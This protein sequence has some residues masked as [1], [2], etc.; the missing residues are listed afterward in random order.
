MRA[1]FD[2]TDIGIALNVAAQIVA[3]DG[4][5]FL[6]IFLRLETEFQAISG[7]QSALQRAV[8]LTH[9]MTADQSYHSC[10]LPAH[11]TAN[12]SVTR[13]SPTA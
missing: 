9:G 3:R 6:P 13:I 7:R 2:A 10:R 11:G 1:V 12:P 8:A 5:R 4:E